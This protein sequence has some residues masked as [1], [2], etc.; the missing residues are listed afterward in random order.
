MKTAVWK[1]FLVEIR[2]RFG[3]FLVIPIKF[4]GA[5]CRS[6]QNFKE[7]D[8]FFIRMN[9]LFKINMCSS[10][11]VN[12]QTTKSVSYLWKLLHHSSVII[13]QNQK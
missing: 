10:T 1:G 8:A 6:M 11:I 12:K 7:I 4:E 3:G 9:F 5:G 2:Q 13:Y